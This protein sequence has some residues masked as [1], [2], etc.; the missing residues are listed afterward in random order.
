MN[1]RSGSLIAALCLALTTGCSWFKGPVN[2]SPSLRWWLFSNFGVGRLCPEMLGR[3]APLRLAPDPNV[4]GRLFPGGC[5]TTVND[6]VQTVTLAFSGSGFAWTPVAGRVAFTVLA[7]VEYRMDFYLADD[8]VYIY[9]RPARTVLG[10]T[11]QVTAIENPLANWAAQG[12]AGYLMNTFGGQVVS[13]ELA[14]GFTVVHADDGDSFAL[15][16]LAPPARPPHPFDTS[17]DRYAMVN[18]TAE[19]HADQLDLIGPLTVAKNDQA[20]FVQFA[21]TGPPLDV[22][23]LRRGTGDLWR[24]GLQNGAPLGPPPEAPVFGFNLT[25]GAPFRQKFALPAGQ[26]YLA[27]D[28]SGRVGTANPGWSPLGALGQNTA[29]LSCAVE[30]GDA[31][32]DF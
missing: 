30:L 10:P 3:S 4:I 14:S 11:F 26:Y 17:K 7:S 18:E 28:N 16:Q 6:S 29:T 19:V 13:G 24:Q 1:T 21:L 22:L 9:A 25:P 12:P 15:G 23:V 8:A 32:D 20:I 5:Q 27:I 2:A 31:D